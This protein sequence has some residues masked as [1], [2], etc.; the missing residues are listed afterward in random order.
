MTFVGKAGP[1]IREKSSVPS[2]S[3]TG[4]TKV[5]IVD[6]TASNRELFAELFAKPG[7]ETRTAASGSD[8]LWIGADW[9]PDLVLMDL[10]MPG[11]NGIEAIRRLRAAGSKAA[12]GALSASA[13]AEDERDALASGPTSSSRS[14][15]R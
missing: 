8:A 5:L 13:S 2:F 7:V 4:A 11:M 15:A 3:A 10:R 12:I 6:D 1:E 9:S 14:R